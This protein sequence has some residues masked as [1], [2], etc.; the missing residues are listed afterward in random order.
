VAAG[1]V[2]ALS[3]GTVGSAVPWKSTRGG[4]R[5]DAV[6]A[7]SAFLLAMGHKV[8]IAHPVY[9]LYKITKEIYRTVH[10]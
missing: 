9:F 2:V 3:K 10:E 6:C 4:D 1:L 8:N 5:G 7:Y